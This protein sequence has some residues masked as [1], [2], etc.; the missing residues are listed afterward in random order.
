MIRP[1][2]FTSKATPLCKLKIPSN[3]APFP[4]LTFELCSFPVNKTIT[5]SSFLCL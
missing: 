1:A 4:V 2:K 3:S 5:I